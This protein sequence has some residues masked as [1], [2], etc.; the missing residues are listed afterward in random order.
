MTGDLAA[1][2]LPAIFVPITGIV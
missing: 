2:W 1:A